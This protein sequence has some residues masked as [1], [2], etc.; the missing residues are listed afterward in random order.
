MR[1]TSSPKAQHLAGERAWRTE[2]QVQVSA[3]A[4]LSSTVSPNCSYFH[5]REVTV[6]ISELPDA[7]RKFTAWDLTI[8]LGG[9]LACVA[10]GVLIVLLFDQQLFIEIETLKLSMLSC[11][12]TLPIFAMNAFVLSGLGPVLNLTQP[13]RQR[14]KQH[15]L[16]WLLT[17]TFLTLYCA[18][19]V[20]AFLWPQAIAG[21]L[22]ITLGLDVVWAVPILATM[23]F[24]ESDHDA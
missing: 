16:F 10:P 1:G 13:P 8:L 22:L 17:W 2:C 23:R 14:S 12:I 5:H 4:A 18:L 20:Q 6:S 19:A 9:F 15:L 24:L 7:V 11:A 3:A 21:F